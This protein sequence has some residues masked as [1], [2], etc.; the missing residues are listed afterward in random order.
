MRKIWRQ[1]LR[2][3]VPYDAGK[4]L[5]QLAAELGVP[6]LARLSANENPLG[7]SPR[8]VEA[9]AREAARVHLYPDGGATALRAALARR[10]GVTPGELLVGNGAD[11]LIGLIARAAFEPGDEVVVPEPSFEPYGIS[12]TIA[13]ARAVPSPL[14]GYATDLEDVRRKVTDRTTAVMLCSPHNPTATIVREKPLR[15]F[16]DALGDDPPLVILD[17]AYRDFVD[18][19]EYPDGVALLRRHPRLI[20]LRTFS[21]IAA[22]AG[23]RV[24]YAVARA[25]TLDWLN[26]VREPYNVNRLG[27][28]A[29]LTALEDEAHWERSRRFVI[30]ERRFLSEGLGRRG[31]TFPPSQSNFLLVKVP[32]A[33]ALREKLLRAGILVRDGADVGFPGHL[34]ISVGLRATNEKLLSLL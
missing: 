24:G 34:R 6:E 5:E 30:E 23:L 4:P 21:K 19:P 28:V 22:L 14:A 2:S 15:A 18:D 8:V 9:V 27:Q 7:P 13:G 12:A 1:G 11:E 32:E 26:R 3:L 17:E 29:A 25:E 16:L 33:A 20:L 10:L 31:Y